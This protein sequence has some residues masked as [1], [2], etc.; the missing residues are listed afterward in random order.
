MSVRDSPHYSFIATD[1]GSDT[2][3]DASTDM[4]TR[5]AYP[6][7]YALGA[8]SGALVEDHSLL[9]FRRLASEFR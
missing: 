8:A 3:T 4:D 7:Y 5:A 9:A 1:T 2:D 6:A